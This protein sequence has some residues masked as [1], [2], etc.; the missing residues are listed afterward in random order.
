MQGCAENKQDAEV[1]LAVWIPKSLLERM[2]SYGVQHDLSV[3][4]ITI[5]AL[6]LFLDAKAQ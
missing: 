5:C 1:L 4:E 6:K 2:K 3:K